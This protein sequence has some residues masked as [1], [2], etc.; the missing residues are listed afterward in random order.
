M[1][2]KPENRQEERIPCEIHVILYS[3]STSKIYYPASIYNHSENGLYI[4]TNADLKGN[5]CYLVKTID[6]NV[7]TKKS[8][9]CRQ[10]FGIVRWAQYTDASGSNKSSYKYGY[11]MEYTK[12][13]ADF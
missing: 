4:E 12:P 3:D 5:H 1:V 2:E 7:D 11:G 8:V 9:E 6:N 10:F 13:P